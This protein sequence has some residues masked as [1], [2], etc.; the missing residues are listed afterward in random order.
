[1]GLPHTWPPAL[2]PGGAEV[3][4]C[5][6]LIEFRGG[7]RPP[8]C[9]GGVVQGCGCCCPAI[10]LCYFLASSA[11]GCDGASPC[12]DGIALQAFHIGHEGIMQGQMS[13][14]AAAL[15]QEKA[16]LCIQLEVCSMMVGSWRLAGQCAMLGMLMRCQGR[17]VVGPPWRSLSLGQCLASNCSHHFHLLFR[18]LCHGTTAIASCL[19]GVSGHPAMAHMTGNVG[20]MAEAALRAACVAQP[21]AHTRSSAANL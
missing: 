12:P 18:A 14:R 17:P 8:R 5:C 4:G 11:L 10:D 9:D 13:S 1:M 7:S 19:S 20:L 16:A 2:V 21:N 15:Q 6:L 3:D